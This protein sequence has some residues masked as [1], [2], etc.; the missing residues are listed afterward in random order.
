MRIFKITYETLEKAL[1]P[2]IKLIIDAILANNDSFEFSRDP[3]TKDIIIR[4]KN[5]PRDLLIHGICFKEFK[6]CLA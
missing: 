2:D 3:V 4:C 5:K 1:N 6:R